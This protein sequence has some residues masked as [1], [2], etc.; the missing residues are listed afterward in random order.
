MG[1]AGRG[2]PL[3][4][5]ARGVLAEALRVDEVPAVPQQAESMEKRGGDTIPRYQRVS[6]YA[7]D[8]M[9]VIPAE[10]WERMK[11]EAHDRCMAEHSDAGMEPMKEVTGIKWC[12]PGIP[13]KLPPT[14]GVREGLME[15]IDHFPR[16]LGRQARRMFNTWDRGGAMEVIA[17]LYDAELEASITG[18]DRTAVY[19][20]Y[21]W[22]IP[23]GIPVL[24]FILALHNWLIGHEDFEFIANLCKELHRRGLLDD[25]LEV[26]LQITTVDTHQRPQ[27]IVM[28]PCIT[29]E[30]PPD[31]LGWRSGPALR[32]AA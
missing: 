16:R 25:A 30:G 20:E 23:Y 6:P 4:L 22:D 15:T 21:L 10:E 19:L 2:A 28:R 32:P 1:L 5:P 26:T 29:A 3:D 7:G 18:V 24:R 11:A 12:E 17:I 27:P 8:V 14:P 31:S 13:N 9:P